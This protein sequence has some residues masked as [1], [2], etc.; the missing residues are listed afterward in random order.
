M[1]FFK[2][3]FSGT[4]PTE[5][6]PTIQFG[7]FSDSYKEEEKYDD[8]DKALILFEKADYLQT[9]RYFFSYLA[10]EQ[11]QN[12]TFEQKG[13]EITFSFYQGSKLIS[14]TAD[15]KK[16]YAEAKIASL[17]HND[18]G[19][20]RRLLEENFQL[21][22][23]RYAI[24]SDQCLT[25]IFSTFALDA[26]PYK[27]YYALKELATTADKTDDVLVSRYEALESIN[28]HHVRA[29]STEEK[30]TK[31][32]FLKAALQE[33]T[34]IIARCRLDFGKH[35]GALSYVYLDLVYK[36]DYLLKPE[37]YTMDLVASLT[38][39][40]F[41]ENTKSIEDKNEALRKALQKLEMHPQEAFFEE[42]YEVKSTF[43][44]T[45]PSGQ[46]R[47]V[48]FIKDEVSNM[49]WYLD[50]GHQ[51]IALAIP[52]YIVGYCLYS[53][54]MPLPLRALLELFYRVTEYSYFEDLG[55]NDS[56]VADSSNLSPAKIKTALRGIFARYIDDYDSLDKNLRSLQFHTIFDFAKSYLMLIAD[57]DYTRKDLR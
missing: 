7:R 4:K 16:F 21:R 28:T 32:N 45:S 13:S 2:N 3:L 39:D 11:K 8:W 38:K 30:T 49:D 48:A 12:I 56:F 24:D 26:S 53:Y 47:I 9:Y 41:Q 36:I 34:D 1:G 31:Y 50:N 44:T 18:I 14:G 57:L 17:V 55:Y 10:D 27:L 33:T 6:L 46:K 25:I 37:G 29:I 35:P 20:F 23:S 15:G 43:G 40:Y 54:S 22:H 42:L 5:N 19:V 51:S 52:S